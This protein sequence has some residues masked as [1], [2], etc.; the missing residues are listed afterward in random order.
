MKKLK[1]QLRPESCQG[2]N[3]RSWLPQLT[4]CSASSARRT[5]AWP[6]TVTVTGWEERL[7]SHLQ[8]PL[9]WR[10][11][12]FRETPS[13]FSFSKCFFRCLRINKGKRQRWAEVP[14]CLPFY[15]SRF[16]TS[17]CSP[18]GNR[19]RNPWIFLASNSLL[20]SGHSSLPQLPCCPAR[21]RLCDMH[22][23]GWEPCL[24]LGKNF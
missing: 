5:P 8:K 13:N 22:V 21:L 6:S 4:P 14:T 12:V 24:H 19:S 15:R 17:E 7:P 18:K 23:E 16:S 20:S 1:L 3:F 9:A 10:W 11:C 2:P